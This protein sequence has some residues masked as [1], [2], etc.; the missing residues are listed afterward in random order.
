[1]SEQQGLDWTGERFV[2]GIK[3]ASALEHIHRYA[4]A[5]GMVSGKIV[6]DIASGE[7]YG[8]NLLAQ[9]AKQVTGVDVSSEAVSH[10]TKKYQRKNLSFIKGSADKIPLGDGICDVVV[11]FE[12]L[13][14]IH[15]Q[16]EMICEI[17][18]V[19]KKDGIMIM[20]TPEKFTWSDKM[21]HKNEYHVKELYKEQFVDLVKRFF[22]NYI[23][24]SQKLVF[25]SLIVPEKKINSYHEYSGNYKEVTSIDHM[26]TPRF[27]IVIASDYDIQEK[28]C[29]VF[30]GDMDPESFNM[31]PAGIRKSG[32]YRIGYFLVTPYRF[33]KKILKTLKI[34]K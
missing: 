31:D 10:A 20:S 17:K 34:L 12:T 4:V 15:A 1:M 30:L 13:E 32:S 26:G 19:L 3:D 6:L 24:M 22:K 8:S 14:H 29:S 27:N 25:S 9:S 23:F 16:D 7:G 18:R 11:S 28:G 33:I 5:A 2:T 21:H